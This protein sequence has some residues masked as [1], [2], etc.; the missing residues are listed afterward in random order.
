MKVL[1]T[2]SRL[3]DDISQRHQSHR[4]DLQWCFTNARQRV[5]LSGIYCTVGEAFGRIF[6]VNH[7]SRHVAHGCTNVLILRAQ[8]FETSNF[9]RVA[10][11]VDAA[12][13]QLAEQYCVRIPEWMK[14]PD[15]N[16]SPDGIV[17]I[18]REVSAYY[19]VLAE[20]RIADAHCAQLF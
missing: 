15:I 8:L 16:E 7:V 14:R 6:Q 2:K 11:N 1:T 13:A 20:L 17:E 4:S 3:F 12:P 5:F 18:L 9:H 10:I 19:Q